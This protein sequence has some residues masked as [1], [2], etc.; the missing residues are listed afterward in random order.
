MAAFWRKLFGRSAKKDDFSQPQDDSGTQL[1]VETRFST[2]SVSLEKGET[3]LDGM[4]R[5]NISI[6]YSCVEGVCGSCQCKVLSGEVVMKENL[7]LTDEEIDKGL[8]LACQSTA[9][10]KHVKV[11]L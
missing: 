6:D 1:T 8:V 5:N 10:S 9:K 2:H 11:K 3:L 4:L 7:F